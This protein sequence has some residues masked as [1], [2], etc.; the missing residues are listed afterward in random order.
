MLCRPGQVLPGLSRGGARMSTLLPAKMADIKDADLFLRWNLWCLGRLQSDPDLQARRGGGAAAAP[1]Q[2]AACEEPRLPLPSC[3]PAMRAR[4]KPSKPL[5]PAK[6]IKKPLN[7]SQT[8][9]NP[10][11]GGL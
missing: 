7:L 4:A 8:T 1:R 9:Q 5:T 6:P 3:K 2:R 10:G 11:G